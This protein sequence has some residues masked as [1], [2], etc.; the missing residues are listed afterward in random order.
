MA[1][2]LTKAEQRG[3]N[4]MWSLDLELT[5]TDLEILSGFCNPFLD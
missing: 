1:F 5:T 2:T 4:N 3:I